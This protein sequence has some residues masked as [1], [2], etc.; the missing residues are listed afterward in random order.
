MSIASQLKIMICEKIT[1]KKYAGIVCNKSK[2]DEKMKKTGILICALAITAM[3][4]GKSQ[5]AYDFKEIKFD[6][7][8]SSCYQWICETLCQ[9]K[10]SAPIVP[11]LPE[12]PEKPSIP[13]APTTPGA[14]STPD[15]EINASAYELEVLDLVNAER[16]KKGLSKLTWSDELANVARAHSKDMLNRK[17]FSHTNPDGQSPFDRMRAAGIRYSSAG[18]NIAA[19]QRTPQE[20]VNAWMNSEGHRANILNASFTKL[21]V[22]YVTGNG[23]YS[24]YWTQNFAG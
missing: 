5:A 7:S 17:F 19:G 16:A 2:G 1:Y 4:G 8:K 10:P 23:A 14:P 12:T 9:M 21:G 13:D 3:L 15:I 18:E 20:V 11:S 24:T 6:F 22:G